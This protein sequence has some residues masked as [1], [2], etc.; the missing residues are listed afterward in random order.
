MEFSCTRITL[1]LAVQLA[2]LGLITPLI[3]IGN[4][5]CLPNTLFYV[6]G[7]TQRPYCRSLD[8]FFDQNYPQNEFKKLVGVAIVIGAVTNQSFWEQ[9]ACAEPVNE[10]PVY[11]GVKKVT[12]VPASSVTRLVDIVSNTSTTLATENCLSGVL[13]YM[14]GQTTCPHCSSQDDFFKQNFPNNYF[15]CP[16]DKYQE[17]YNAASQFASFLANK[18]VPLNIA[19]GIPQI[20]VVKND[21]GSPSI[22]AVVIGELRERSFWLQIA[23]STP[24]TKIPVYASAGSSG[25][26]IAEINVN[27]TNHSELIGNYVVFPKTPSEEFN[28][29]ILGVVIVIAVLAITIG[30]YTIYVHV[31]RRVEKQTTSKKRA[32]RT[33]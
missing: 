23:C 30:S 14:Y 22:L 33:A 3:V 27:T 26:I 18:G 2:L 7:S 11:S 8:T 32:R 19:T 13:F 20:I 25:F 1:M 24:D 12:S 29:Q 15:Y 16:I 17:C 4:E 28:S 10:I 9:L 31:H 5:T 6:Y 21:T